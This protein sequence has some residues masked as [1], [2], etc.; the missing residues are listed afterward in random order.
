MY[1]SYVGMAKAAGA[2]IKTVPLQ[3][4]HF[5]VTQDQLEAA[6]SEKTKLILVN[7][8][9]NPTGGHCSAAVLQAGLRHGM[10]ACFCMHVQQQAWPWQ[11]A[12]VILQL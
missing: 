10:H 6:F 12:D 4:P 11:Q 8:P 2:V 7:T 5:S 3:P 9:H 1:D